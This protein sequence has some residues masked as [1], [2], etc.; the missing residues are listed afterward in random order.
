MGSSAQ[1]INFNTTNHNAYALAS[2]VLKWYNTNDYSREITYFCMN[3]SEEK[4]YIGTSNG[5]YI[6]IGSFTPNSWS[7]G[8]KMEVYAVR[9][10][11][12]ALTEEEIR[13][14]YEIDKV[15]FNIQE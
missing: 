14:N 4:D 10:Y 8:A 13:Q 11:N 7:Q 3:K 6:S 15:R 12:R 9:V 1:R 2:R 5:N